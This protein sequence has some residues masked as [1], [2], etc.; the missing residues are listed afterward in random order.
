MF[1]ATALYRQLT[2]EVL[3]IKQNIHLSNNQR[4][5]FFPVFETREQANEFAESMLVAQGIEA[6]IIEI[7]KMGKV[8]ESENE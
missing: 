1:I 2:A 3:G 8:L 5:G 7:D 6:N 4:L